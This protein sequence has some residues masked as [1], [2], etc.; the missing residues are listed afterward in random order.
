[1]IGVDVTLEEAV[2]YEEDRY[3]QNIDRMSPFGSLDQDQLFSV[4]T[5]ILVLKLQ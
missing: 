3:L 4:V 2:G 5:L 1:M